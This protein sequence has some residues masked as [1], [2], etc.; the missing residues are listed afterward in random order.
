[1]RGKQVQGDGMRVHHDT[2]MKTLLRDKYV[3]VLKL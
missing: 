3:E 1:M 2:D